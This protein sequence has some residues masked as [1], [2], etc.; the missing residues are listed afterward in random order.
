MARPPFSILFVICLLSTTSIIYP[1]L[2]QLDIPVVY[3]LYPSIISTYLHYICPPFCWEPR[4]GP[5][6]RAQAIDSGDR[7]TRHPDFGR[8]AR[9]AWENHGGKR[10]SMHISWYKWYKMHMKMILNAHFSWISKML[11]MM[12]IPTDFFR[13]ILAVNESGIFLACQPSIRNEGPHLIAYLSIKR[14]E[15][16]WWDFGFRHH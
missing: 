11:D 1:Y 2:I 8:L 16:Y 6:Y 10:F 13:A 9:L 5:R 15:R 4:A 3:P 14:A 12:G 7:P